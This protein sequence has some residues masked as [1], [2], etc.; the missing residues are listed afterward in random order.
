MGLSRKNIEAEAS[1]LVTP[2]IKNFP[3]RDRI[4]AAALKLFVDQGYFNTNVPD[5]SRESK[6]SVGSIYHNFKNKEEV[7]SALYEEGINAFR[8][9]L[10][11]SL[12]GVED[13]E[14]IVKT[15]IQ[16]F[17]MF[18]EVNQQLSRYLW[19]SRHAEFMTGDIKPPTMIGFD[20]LGRKLTRTLKSA[21][22]D[23]HIRPMRAHVIWSIIFGIPLSYVRDWF[24]GYNPLPPTEVAEP[25]SEACWRALI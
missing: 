11:A 13:T 17:L 18:S 2:D 23:G 10:E 25:I 21:I 6:C 3:P 19:L 24:D 8:R 16:S 1:A 7:A 14:T 12:E 5:L 15:L 20:H 4:L 22:R 9:T